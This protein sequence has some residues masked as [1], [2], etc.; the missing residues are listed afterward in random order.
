MLRGYQ[1]NLPFKKADIVLIPKGTMVKKI[2]QTPKPAGRTYKVKVDHVLPGMSIPVGTYWPN[3]ERSL[4]LE[5]MCERSSGAY[6][7]K[8]AYGTLNL[9]DLIFFMTWEERETATGKKY[10]RLFLPIENPKVCWAGTGG[11]WAEADVND[12]QKV[13]G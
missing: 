4:H 7:I 8:R 9:K 2:G 13:D 3:S 12:V 11:Y 1:N 5:E 6:D 10:L